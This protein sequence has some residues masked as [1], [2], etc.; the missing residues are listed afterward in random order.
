MLGLIPGGEPMTEAEW[1]KC[2][3]P[4]DMLLWLDSGKS[5]ERKGLLL[6][7][8]AW[9]SGGEEY[10]QPGKTL[11]PAFA[12]FAE[13]DIS[14]EELGRLIGL[15]QLGNQAPASYTAGNARYLIATSD[16]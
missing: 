7:V 11:I 2:R 10:S 12:R 3:Y 9:T 5:S 6:L 14:R 1:L 8:A 4:S 15:E 13:G 16:T